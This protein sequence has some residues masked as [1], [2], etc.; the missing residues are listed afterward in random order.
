MEFKSEGEFSSLV[1]NTASVPNIRTVAHDPYRSGTPPDKIKLRSFQ[2]SHGQHRPSHWPISSPDSLLAASSRKFG[3][4]CCLTGQRQA[5]LLKR[6]SRFLAAASSSFRF[7][8]S[9]PNLHFA[10]CCSPS[11]GKSTPIT[12]SP[13]N[14]HRIALTPVRRLHFCR[15][16]RPPRMKLKC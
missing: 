6:G 7:R 15:T 10:V 1:V 8:F 16:L 12:T 14:I 9:H 4:V 11:P 3:I 2:T 5:L 13:I